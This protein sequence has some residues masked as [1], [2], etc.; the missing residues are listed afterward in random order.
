MHSSLPG[1]AYEG[2]RFLDQIAVSPHGAFSGQGTVG[3]RT[4]KK[5]RGVQPRAQGLDGYIQ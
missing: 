5:A 1:N 2:Q 4:S 3:A